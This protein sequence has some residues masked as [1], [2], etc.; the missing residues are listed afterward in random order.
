MSQSAATIG[1]PARRPVTPTRPTLQLV[2]P[3]AGKASNLPFVLL[4]SFVLAAGLLVVLVLNMQ[5]SAGSYEMDKLQKRSDVA[6]DTAAKLREDLA[7]ESATGKLAQRATDLGMV[8]GT[9]AM[10]LSLPDGKILGVA[11]K[12]PAK[13]PMKVAVDGGKPVQPTSSAT[14]SAT[15]GTTNGASG[16]QSSQTSGQTS[17]QASDQAQ[18]S[19]QPS[20]Q[21]TKA[22]QA[23][24]TTQPTARASTTDQT[25]GR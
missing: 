4:C 12:D 16:Q 11:P 5:L 14:G 7:A 3:V 19:T 9:A 21:S 22:S 6:A 2:T 8:P 18:R 1:R 25:Q 10:F 23:Q 20:A 15:T 13:D 17:G 24:R